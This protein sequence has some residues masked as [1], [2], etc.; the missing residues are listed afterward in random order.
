MNDGVGPRY[1]KTFFSPAGVCTRTWK[2]GDPALQ[3]SSVTSNSVWSVEMLENVVTPVPA[4]VA[5]E[6]SFV[7]PVSLV[8]DTSV[9]IP[10]LTVAPPNGVAVAA[11]AA[12]AATAATAATTATMMSLLM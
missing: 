2:R 3:S 10:P 8:S 9:R 7:V 12:G 5:P 1:T 4:K 6:A 11:N